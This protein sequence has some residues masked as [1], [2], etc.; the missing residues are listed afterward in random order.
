MTKLVAIDAGHGMKT[1]GKRTPKLKK[2]L[3][4]IL[5]VRSFNILVSYNILFLDSKT[6]RFL[7]ILFLSVRY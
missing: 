1:D 5:F 3:I 2:D 4:I 7:K 6:V